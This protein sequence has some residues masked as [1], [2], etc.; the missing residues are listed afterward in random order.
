MASTISNAPLKLS[1]KQNKA[2]VALTDLFAGLIKGKGL[3]VVEWI[4]TDIEESVRLIRFQAGK[5]P[6]Q[7]STRL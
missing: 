7:G 6:K 4:V 5:T 3:I 2:K 1:D